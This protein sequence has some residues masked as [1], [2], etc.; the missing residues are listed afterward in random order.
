MRNGICIDLRYCGGCGGC[1]MA[2]KV[3]N[4]TLAGTYWC[5]LYTKERGTYPTVKKVFLPSACMHCQDA[6]CIAHCPTRASYHDADG[7]VLIDHKKCIGC[8][9]CINA[10][11]YNARHYNFV[12]ASE[13]P[14][15]PGQDLTPF[16]EVKAPNHPIGKTGKCNL[17]RDR[18]A[19]GEIPACVETCFTRCR[20]FGDLDDPNSEISKKVAQFNAKP[21]H[22]NIGTKPNVYYVGDF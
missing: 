22:E 19:K 10:C 21:L 20:T 17:C 4:G 6:P 12:K 2:C 18:L 8:R 7:A 11:P 5:N 9:A 14:Y 15:Y 1:V 3:E 13:N 16:E